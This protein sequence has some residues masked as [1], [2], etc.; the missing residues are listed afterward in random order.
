MSMVYRKG[1]SPEKRLTVE[2]QHN[3]RQLRCFRL[4]T[5]GNLRLL[6]WQQ[7]MLSYVLQTVGL[8]NDAILLSN[9]KYQL[10]QSYAE[11]S[12]ILLNLNKSH[13]KNFDGC[14]WRWPWRWVWRIRVSSRWVCRKGRRW[15]WRSVN[16][17]IDLSVNLT[18]TK[19]RH[20]RSLRQPI[21]Q[22]SRMRQ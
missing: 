12:R 13:L 14:M 17:T 16:L 10:H 8:Q 22:A 11:L 2:I 5:S 15:S 4:Q 6:S 9:S 21:R 18:I 19:T 20:R 1:I 7:R 3:W